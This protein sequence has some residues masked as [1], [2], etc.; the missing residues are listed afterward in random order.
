[1]QTGA[2]EQHA[3]R[4][5]TGSGMPLAGRERT[6][7]VPGVH[8]RIE[9]GVERR[10][11][12]ARNVSAVGQIRE[13]REVDRARAVAAGARVLADHLVRRADPT[14]RRE[15]SRKLL[16]SFGQRW[17]HL[18][19]AQQIL[20]RAAA[21]VSC[22]AAACSEEIGPRRALA[23]HGGLGP[24]SQRTEQLG[25][26]GIVVVQF[27]GLRQHVGRGG[28]VGGTRQQRTHSRQRAARH[29]TGLLRGQRPERCR[30]QRGFAESREPTGQ[31]F[32]EL[33]VFAQQKRAARE[34]GG[35][36]QLRAAP[37]QQTRER[38]G[39]LALRVHIAGRVALGE[40]RGEVAL[41]GARAHAPGD[42]GVRFPPLERQGRGRSRAFR[43]RPFGRRQRGPVPARRGAPGRRSGFLLEIG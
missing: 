28:S 20:E 29:R 40:P 19:S 43:T 27:R 38:R 11:D 41:F 25:G 1:M 31:L 2:I 42:R 21:L 15:G 13:P 16:R 37:R 36:V 23:G 33:R 34:A 3:E 7:S 22:F 35:G 9:T 17:R 14:T 5:R 10:P 12:R 4:R 18:E 30:S 24:R 26:N 32:A 8:D 6:P 39:H